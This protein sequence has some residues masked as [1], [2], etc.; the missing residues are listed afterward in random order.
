MLKHF[1]LRAVATIKVSYLCSGVPDEAAISLS[2]QYFQRFGSTERRCEAWLCSVLTRFI[3]GICSSGPDLFKLMTLQQSSVQANSR[4]YS[5][6]NEVWI[7]RVHR[8]SRGFVT[9]GEL[10]SLPSPPGRVASPACQ[11]LIKDHPHVGAEIRSIT[12]SITKVLGRGCKSNS[13]SLP[14]AAFW[15]AG[16]SWVKSQLPWPQSKLCH[17]FL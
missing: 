14:A 4:G 10:V 6:P 16:W 13:Y 3:T 5:A 7:S 15:I 11:E 12:W 1:D 8:P 17:W 9:W 2:L